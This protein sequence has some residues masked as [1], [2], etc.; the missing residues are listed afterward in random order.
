MESALTRMKDVLTLRSFVA[1]IAGGVIGCLLILLPEMRSTPSP[2]V[3]AFIPRTTGINLAE[4]M[5]KGAQAAA[6][7]A[8][9]RIYWNAPTMEDDVDRQ[10]RITESAVRR[11]A[12]AVI[13][14][15]TNP[16]GVTTMLEELQNHKVPIVIVQAE[17]PIPAGPY[18][19]SLTPDQSQFGRLA[20][21]RAMQITGG[22]GEVAI[23]GL[24]RATPETF[25]RARSFVEALASHPAIEIVTQAQG[26]V[27][28]LEA[29]QSARAVIHAFPALRVIF[30]VS[31][32]ATQGAVLALDNAEPKPRIALIGCDRDL[33]LADDLS[34]GKIDS[35]VGIDAYSTGFQAMVAAVMGAGGRPLPMPRH[36]PVTLFTRETSR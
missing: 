20:A 34:H 7:I 27:Q 33:F 25:T 19:T 17:S 8:G 12:R 9:Y 6:Q 16:R 15:P 29:E 32:D 14:G 35:L 10:I 21:V 5:H 11:G 22:S 28:I 13:L 4:D 1:A 18:L 30:A 24:D 31:A 23:L 26:S 3:I 36:I 2:P